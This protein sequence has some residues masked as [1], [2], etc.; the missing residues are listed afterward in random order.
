MRKIKLLKTITIVVCFLF[1]FF[2]K[3]TAADAA[4][5]YMDDTGSDNNSCEQAKSTL[6]PK[7]T[8]TS[9]MS[10]VSTGDTI[11][12]RGGVYVG[13]EVI[14]TKSG[15]AGNEIT[16]KAYAGESPIFNGDGRN[17][18]SFFMAN[19][20]QFIHHI[21]IDGLE[22]YDYRNAFLLYAAFNITVKN[23]YIHDGGFSGA[24]AN[25]YPSTDPTH[26]A[27]DLLI[28]NNRFENIG[29]DWTDCSSASPPHSL[30]FISTIHSTIRNNIFINMY[31]CRV[32][33]TF[34]G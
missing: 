15:T 30:Y 34:C 14:W 16:I 20:G 33:V 13:Q 4:T 5:Y 11:E 31:C 1:L 2:F 23:N 19:P 18:A 12:I 21:I 27:M 9:L 24:L 7:A 32:K 29:K 26:F 17:S 28:E 8:L 6:T 25:P 3:T 22:I 10:C